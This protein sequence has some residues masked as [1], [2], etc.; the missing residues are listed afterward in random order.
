VD[1]RV[2]KVSFEEFLERLRSVEELDFDDTSDHLTE[3]DFAFAGADLPS[4]RDQE[5]A[6][7]LAG[8]QPCLKKLAALREAAER[9]DTSKLDVW[10]PALRESF[11]DRNLLHDAVA[12]ATRSVSEALTARLTGW[13]VWLK[14]GSTNAFSTYSWKPAFAGGDLAPDAGDADLDV[15]LK[16]PY[17]ICRI[18]VPAKSSIN[19]MVKGEE[20]AFGPVILLQLEAG[21]EPLIASSVRNTELPFYCARFDS[22]APGTYLIAMSPY[23]EEK[24]N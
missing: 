18:E 13:G 2:I 12:R 19:V 16:S 3:E 10:L 6:S 9:L 23:L 20:R 4:D 1:K 22:I 5:V 11:A 8:C 24:V 7:H 21:G 14:S 17:E 15:L